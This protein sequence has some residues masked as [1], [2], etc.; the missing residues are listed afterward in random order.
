MYEG[1]PIPYSMAQKWQGDYHQIITV[2]SKTPQNVRIE[3]FWE[4][5]DIVC[6]VPGEWNRYEIRTVVNELSLGTNQ[7][8][9]R[10]AKQF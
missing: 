6:W 10:N 1:V 4:I 9:W 2:S 5:E 7:T 3:H 8:K